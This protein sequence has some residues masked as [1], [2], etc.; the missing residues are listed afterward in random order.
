[1]AFKHYQ[2]SSRR[3]MIPP[4][5]CDEKRV[6]QILKPTGMLTL[7]FNIAH[8]VTANL[9]NKIEDIL[10]VNELYVTPVNLFFSIF[11]LLH[12]EHVL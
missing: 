7:S 2:A 11:F 10:I 4:G 3:A 5:F 8:Y 12:L 9:F 6:Y 1:M